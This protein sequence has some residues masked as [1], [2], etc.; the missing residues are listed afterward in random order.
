MKVAVAKPIDAQNYPDFTG[1]AC[2]TVRGQRA[3]LAGMNTESSQ[4][5]IHDRERARRLCNAGPCPIRDSICR[6]WV[7]TQEQPAGAWGAVWG[8]LDPWNRRGIELVWDPERRIAVETPF[9]IEDY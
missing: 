2:T 9:R 4:A 5:G 1:G 8:G 3:A 6:P 7:L